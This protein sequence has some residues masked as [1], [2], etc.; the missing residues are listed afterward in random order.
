MSVTILELW[1]LESVSIQQCQENGVLRQ[2]TLL[3][4]ARCV[5]YRGKSIHLRCYSIEVG[6]LDIKHSRMASECDITF[7]QYHSYEKYT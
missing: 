7:E 2:R 5:V 4:R 6:G 1:H 3:K